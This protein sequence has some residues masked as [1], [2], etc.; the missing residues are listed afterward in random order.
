MVSRD[1][2]RNRVINKRGEDYGEAG[3]LTVPVTNGAMSGNPP[4]THVGLV[5]ATTLW[6]RSEDAAGRTGRRRRS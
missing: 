1:I 6:W 2:T 5:G 4:S 3:A